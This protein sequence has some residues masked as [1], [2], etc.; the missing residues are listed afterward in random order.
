[1][2]EQSEFNL[3]QVINCAI[4]LEELSDSQLPLN[5]RMKHLMRDKGLV[6]DDEGWVTPRDTPPKLKG[7]WTA[8]QNQIDLSYEITQSC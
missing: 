7:K 1:M 2:S 6:L 8:T 5:I 4:H 3:G